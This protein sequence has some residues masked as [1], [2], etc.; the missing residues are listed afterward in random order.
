MNKT[1]SFL[2][3][4][5]VGL[6][7]GILV[8]ISNAFLSVYRNHTNNLLSDIIISSLK[9]NFQLNHSLVIF[10]NYVIIGIIISLILSSPK[11]T[12]QIKGGFVLL[13]LYYLS[14]FDLLKI[15]ESLA[16][17]IIILVNLIT[18]AIWYPID[19]LIYYGHLTMGITYITANIVIVFFIGMLIVRIY[20]KKRM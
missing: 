16:V 13:A 8:L 18:T 7:F 17:I 1:K 3:G 11:L 12:A 2:R 4:A 10:V 20:Q 19:S 15:I 6:A 9:Y 5:L 14:F